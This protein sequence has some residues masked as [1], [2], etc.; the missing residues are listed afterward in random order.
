MYRKALD[1][2]PNE[3]SVLSN[4][5]MSYVLG[6]DLRAAETLLAELA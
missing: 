6:N 1:I 3:P 5:G 4:L 2:M